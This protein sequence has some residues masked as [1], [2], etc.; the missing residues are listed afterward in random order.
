M[1]HYYLS[2]NVICRL[3]RQSAEENFKNNSAT[4][5]ES[6]DDLLEV[7]YNIRDESELVY[8]NTIDELCNGLVGWPGFENVFTVSALHGDGVEDLN[9]YLMERAYPSYGYWE[10]NQDLVTTK[11]NH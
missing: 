10:Y 7:L 9:R 11:V 1:C 6:Y 5:I 4:V 3:E 2:S 8:A